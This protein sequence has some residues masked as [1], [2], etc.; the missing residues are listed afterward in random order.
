M[1]STQW[2]SR[3]LPAFL[4]ALLMAPSAAHANGIFG[5]MLHKTVGT[6][7][8]NINQ[9]KNQV[10]AVARAAPTT[11]PSGQPVPTQAV[12]G[13]SGSAPQDPNAVPLVRTFQPVIPSYSGAAEDLLGVRLGMP[14]AQ[15]EKIASKTYPDS[16]VVQRFKYRLAYKEVTVE[17]QPFVQ[18]VE[19]TK[20][21]ANTTDQ[22]LLDF[23]SPVGDSR[24]VS[25]ERLINFDPHAANEPLVSSIQASLLKKYGTPSGTNTNA[26]T[27]FWWAYSQKGR[28]PCQYGDCFAD[29][30]ASY[31]VGSPTGGGPLTALRPDGGVFKLDFNLLNQRCGSFVGSPNMQV[32]DDIVRIWASI[33]SNRADSSKAAQMELAIYYSK[34]CVDDVLDARTQMQAAALKRYH[35]ISKTPAAPTF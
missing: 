29:W 4:L 19:Y 35:A 6:V 11:A 5:E 2:Y 22:L 20:A 9:M 27:Q 30:N 26:L 23:N 14:L 12:A 13:S 8:N 18:Y 21:T 24:V 25:M 28:L 31:G 15:A 3:C 34:P 10:N 7:I 16:P 1:G 17:S 32:D 33:S